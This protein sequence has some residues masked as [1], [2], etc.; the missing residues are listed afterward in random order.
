MKKIHIVSLIL[1]SVSLNRVCI[2]ALCGSVSRLVGARKRSS[3]VGCNFYDI[4]QQRK[5]SKKQATK[6]NL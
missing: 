4:V 6:K 5:N 1:L 2:V 3:R